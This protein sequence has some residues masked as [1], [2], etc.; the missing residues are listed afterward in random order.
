MSQHL[1]RKQPRISDEDLLVS[2][3]ATLRDLKR[4]EQTT[5]RACKSSEA[6]DP[7]VKYMIETPDPL[8]PSSTIKNV[9]TEKVKGGVCC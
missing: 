1:V 5:Q 2:L 3:E 7:L 8:N 4:T 6:L 9:Y